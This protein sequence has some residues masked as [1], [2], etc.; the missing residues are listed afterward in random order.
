MFDITAFE[1]NRAL[2][3]R[4]S[5]SV[6]HQIDHPP[7][8]PSRQHVDFMSW[9]QQPH[10]NPKEETGQQANNLS[11]RA[12]QLSIFGSMVC[13]VYF[14]SLACLGVTSWWMISSLN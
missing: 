11:V 14:T 5:S 6:S 10:D 13:L 2:Q 3:R 1:A 9:P 8:T 7:R 12:M 4:S